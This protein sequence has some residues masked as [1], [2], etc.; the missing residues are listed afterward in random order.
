[1]GP[2]SRIT[3]KVEFNNDP[4]VIFESLTRARMYLQAGE[5]AGNEPPAR[6]VDGPCGE[7]LGGAWSIES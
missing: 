3:T 6:A 1:V 5:Q 4:N 7:L 2:R